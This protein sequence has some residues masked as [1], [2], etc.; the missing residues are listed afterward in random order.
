MNKTNQFNI[1][2]SYV[3]PD[4][5]IA[6]VRARRNILTGSNE[7]GNRWY[8]GGAGTYGEDE[9]NDNGEY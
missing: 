3:S 1:K 4:V 7:P 5:K 9:Q 8:E 2:V 6:T